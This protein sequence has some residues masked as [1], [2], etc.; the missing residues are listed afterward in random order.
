MKMS[1]EQSPMVPVSEQRLYVVPSVLQY[2]CFQGRVS[3]VSV[4]GAQKVD[5]QISVGLDLLCSVR[6]YQ[7]NVVL[8]R[9]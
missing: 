5:R 2:D 9:P 7:G 3:S 4:Q 6:E 1:S 8:L